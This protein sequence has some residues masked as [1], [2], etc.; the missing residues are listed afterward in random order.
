MLEQL[1]AT[2]VPMYRAQALNWIADLGFGLMVA[3]K[4]RNF[5]TLCFVLFF[6]IQVF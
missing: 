3:A 1:V 2:S 4:G 6:F 5:G